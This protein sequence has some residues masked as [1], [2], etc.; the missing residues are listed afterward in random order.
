MQ[1]WSLVQALNA[2]DELQITVVNATGTAQSLVVDTELSVSLIPVAAVIPK[3]ILANSAPGGTPDLQVRQYIAAVNCTAGSAV[4]IGLQTQVTPVDPNQTIHIPFIDGVC[5]NPA[6]TGTVANVGTN[7]G[8][9]YQIPDAN[10]VVG[11]LVYAGLNGALTQDYTTLVTQVDWVCV[12]GKAITPTTLMFQ[13][14]LP[15][16]VAVISSFDGG[17]T[18][19]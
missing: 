1:T 14:H 11:N 5:I 12:V 10:F 17:A 19:L 4:R 7:Y 15:T 3:P 9:E 2:G 8:A 6:V 13:P 18:P 16:R